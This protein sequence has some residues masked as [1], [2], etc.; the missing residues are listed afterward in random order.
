MT[1]CDLLYI[2]LFKTSWVLGK[3]CPLT[4]GHS[5]LLSIAPTVSVLNCGFITMYWVAS[6]SSVWLAD[7]TCGSHGHR[8][9]QPS[10]ALP[11]EALLLGNLQL[12]HLRPLCHSGQNHIPVPPAPVALSQ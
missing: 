12:S 9:T 5:L 8:V 1:C 6:V 11:R 3:A 2:Q 7:G 4:P 10:K